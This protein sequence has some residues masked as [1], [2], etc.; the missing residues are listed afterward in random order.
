MPDAPWAR[1]AAPTP[2]ATESPRFTY[3]PAPLAG[4]ATTSTAMSVSGA[5]RFIA[6]RYTRRAEASKCGYWPT[7]PSASATALPPLSTTSPAVEPTSLTTGAAAGAT[8]A[9]VSAV[10]LVVWR[11]TSPALVVVRCRTLPPGCEPVV[12]DEPEVV[13]ADVTGLDVAGELGTVP[14]EAL[15]RPV[16]PRCTRGATVTA[17]RTRTGALA[18]G[19]LCGAT[20][21]AA[22]ASWETETGVEEPRSSGQP[23]KA[24]TVLTTSRAR[25]PATA[26]DSPAPIEPTSARV[27]RTGDESARIAHALR[28]SLG[29][30]LPTENRSAGRA[31]IPS[32][33]A[34]WASRKI[35]H[36]P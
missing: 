35:P 30:V 12:G 17:G 27:P 16:V 3:V 23:R 32:R 33:R 18:G 11:T 20:L 7:W 31:E 19:R 36:S 15:D 6:R 8:G 34:K 4:A 9:T 24:T 25:L 10:C 1:V 5:R 14:P 21:S 28:A 22:G 29:T 26:S 13:P 2:R